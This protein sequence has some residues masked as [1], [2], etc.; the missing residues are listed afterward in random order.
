MIR[1]TLL[2]FPVTVHWMFWA[3][4]AMLGANRLDGPRGFAML[5]IWVVAGFISILI[6]ELGHT[7]LQRKFGARAEIVLYAMGG[8][9]IPDRGFTRVQQIII[10]LGGPFLQIAVGLVAWQVIGHSSGDAWNVRAFFVSFMIVSIFWGLLN[11]LP[12]YPLDGGQVLKGILGPRRERFAYL[13]GMLCAAGLCIYV[14]TRP[15]PSFW[16]AML[17]GLFAWDNFQRWQGQKPPSALE[18][19]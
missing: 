1:F 6:H 17:C 7:L 2:G 9:A 8:L 16:N 11:L 5:L 4:M 10:S 14:L 12:I 15:H 19:R 13:V 18:P 3:I